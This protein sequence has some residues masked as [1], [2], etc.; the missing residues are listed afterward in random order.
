MALLAV[1]ALSTSCGGG[2]NKDAQ[3]RVWEPY[4]IALGALDE[5]ANAF[6]PA[7]ANL[8]AWFESPSHKVIKVNGFVSRDYTRKLVDGKE[9]LTP[10]GEPQWKIRFTPTEPGEWRYTWM[11]NNSERFLPGQFETL[12]VKPARDDRHGFLRV[13]T[14]DSRYLRFDDG[15]PYFANGENLAWY[16]ARGTYDYDDWFAKLAAQGV[17]YVRL[18]MP[19]WAFGLEWTEPNTLGNYTERLDLAWQLDY[20]LQQAE[21]HGIYVLL[22]IQNHGAFSLTANSEWDKNP[23]NAANGGPLAQPEDVFTNDEAK[24][25]FERRLRYIVARWGASP[26]VLG[27]EL[28]NEVD[29][30]STAIDAIVP[31]HDAMSKELRDLDPYDHLISTST[32]L[33]WGIAAVTATDLTSFDSPLFRFWQ[34]PDVDFSQVHLYALGGS[35]IDFSHAL[36]A[37]SANLR[38]FGKPVLIAEAGV[39]PS[40][41]DE[42]IA[43]DPGGIGFHEM[44]WAGLFAQTMGTGMSW[45]WDNVID[46]QDWYFHFAPLARI[47]KSVDFDHE[48]FVADSATA[49]GTAD[50]PLRAF[51]LTGKTTALVW[52]K[53]DYNQ[54]FAPDKSEIAGATLTLDGVPAG[55]WHAMWLNTYSN[56]IVSEADVAFTGVSLKLDVPAFQRDIALRLDKK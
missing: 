11:M 40:G 24:Q 31:W 1:F 45:W 51:N 33:P 16:G 44:L 32:S 21:A 6:D 17:N 25:L 56:K 48:A 26:N 5:N 14:V 43:A 39:S 7:Q 30:S 35:S 36:P 55:T 3:A 52:I 34:L 12:Q 53:N 2:G 41:P 18:W 27:W 47:T 13:S 23:Y 49:Q 4:E 46:P 54:W 15:T 9:Q 29:L 42:T 20:V 19:S 8:R 37:I 28:W 50:T 22:S 38:R 10:N